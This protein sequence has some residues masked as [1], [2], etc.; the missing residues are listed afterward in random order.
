MYS[1][2]CVFDDKTHSKSKLA[3]KLKVWLCCPDYLVY[4]VKISICDALCPNLMNEDACKV[5]VKR[6]NSRN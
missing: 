4:F 5:N 6:L 3:K 2:L 1:Q